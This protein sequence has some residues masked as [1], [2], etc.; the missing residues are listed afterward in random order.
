M[1]GFYGRI[2]YFQRIE[3]IKDK[4]NQVWH[5]KP[6]HCLLLIFVEKKK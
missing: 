5:R 4:K 3:F 2:N 1:F 6:D